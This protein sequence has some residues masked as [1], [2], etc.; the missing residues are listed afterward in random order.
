MTKFAIQR[1]LERLQTGWRPV[2]QEIDHDVAQRRLAEW[3][4]VPGRRTTPKMKLLGY[5]VEQ[6][7]HADENWMTEWVLW[8]DPGLR[9]ALCDDG[10]YW[11]Q[12]DV[13]VRQY[14]VMSGA[15]V[16]FDTDVPPMQLALEWISGRSIDETLESYPTVSRGALQTAIIK[17]F[18]L[19]NQAAPRVGAWPIDPLE[20]ALRE[21]LD[22]T[23]VEVAGG[24]VY[25][26]QRDTDETDD[27]YALRCLA[28]GCASDGTIRLPRWPR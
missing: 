18:R 10:F 2:T 1:L 13:V 6:V 23:M 9:W 21:F 8:I 27:D 28:L 5:L 17:A 22:D 24:D 19:L 15:P 12:A 20:E 11:L 7:A 26:L 3:N 4:F 16:L 14:G 25:V